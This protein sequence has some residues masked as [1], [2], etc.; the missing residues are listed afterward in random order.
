MTHRISARSSVLFALASLSLPS[1]GFFQSKSEG[2]QAPPTVVENAEVLSDVDGILIATIDPSMAQQVGAS[3][4]SGIAGALIIFPAGSLAGTAEVTVEEGAAFDLE[5][6]KSDLGVP[7][8]LAMEAA[9]GVLVIQA[10]EDIDPLLPLQV[11][12]PLSA[13]AA[14]QPEEGM[15]PALLYNIVRHDLGG[16]RAAGIRVDESIK[17]VGDMVEFSI[18]YFGAYAIVYVPDSFGE[19]VEAETDR[20]IVTKQ[21]ELKNQE[22]QQQEEQ[23]ELE[24]T[25]SIVSSEP[26]ANASDIARPDFLSITFSDFLANNPPQTSLTVTRAGETVGGS[27][28]VEGNQLIFQPTI[29]FLLGETYSVQV[30]K[31]LKSS[32]GAELGAD[33]SFTFA[34]GNGSWR[35]GGDYITDMPAEAQHLSVASLGHGKFGLIADN[36]IVVPELIATRW[37]GAAWVD[38]TVSLV[39]DVTQ[40]LASVGSQGRYFTG[41]LL[42]QSSSAVLPFAD[43]FFSRLSAPLDLSS[44]ASLATYKDISVAAGPNGAVQ[45]AYVKPS[46]FEIEG[47]NFNGTVFSGHQTLRAADMDEDRS[48]LKLANNTQGDIVMMYQGNFS[49]STTYLKV[50]I[51]R[52][53]NDG[54]EDLTIDTD[55]VVTV[56]NRLDFEYLNIFISDYGQVTAFW[57]LSTPQACYARVYEGTSWGTAYERLIPQGQDLMGLAAAAARDRK[58][59]EVIWLRGDPGNKQLE[60]V[61]FN[62][63]GW[64]EPAPLESD[65]DSSLSY[66]DLHLGMDHLGRVQAIWGK[67]EIISGAQKSQ[68]QWSA[69]ETR[70]VSGANPVKTSFAIDPSGEAIFVWSDTDGVKSLSFR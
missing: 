45:F 4:D 19:T 1:C 5:V 66:S 27:L 15:K 37:S 31:T 38:T 42:G 6:M 12:M 63:L 23:P 30:A 29:S 28:R 7:S 64:G 14:L 39:A 41:Y 65:Q 34:I 13:S 53:G 33:Q 20:P 22:E 61:E 62:G 21:E 36:P 25:F 24:V 18:S 48:Q 60:V 55:E 59:L 46:S 8:D 51:K 50:L 26:A 11:S 69:V 3:A 47:R 52:E 2:K 56:N 44:D 9:T 49:F 58:R 16:V 35:E 17:I 57:C 54:W 40:G 32:G 67:N 68:T 43:A 70:V 10:S